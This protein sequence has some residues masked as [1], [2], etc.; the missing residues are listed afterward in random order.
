MAGAVAEPLIQRGPLLKIKE[1][2]QKKRTIS[3]EFFPPREAEGITN[4][5]R[6]IDR[7]SAFG[8]DFVSVTYGAGGSTRAF[9]EEITLHIK[10]ET[11]LEVMAHLTCVGQSQQEIHGVLERLDRAGVDNVIALRGDPPRG[12][13]DFVP[14]AG[15]FRHST[16]LIQHIK[17]NFQFGIAAACY[18]E[19]HTESPDLETDIRYARLKVDLGADFLITQLFYDNSDFF[20]FM[21]RAQQAGI[22]VPIIPGVLP[23]LSASQIRRFTALCGARIPPELD[24]QLD[25]YAGDDQAVRELGIEHASR[26]IRELWDGGVPGVH[27]YVLNR[28]YSVSRILT[29]LGLAD[30]TAGC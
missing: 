11:D 19:G 29:N 14:A 30:G 7:V 15:G 5:L 17:N 26:Q 3:C 24:R 18:P 23:I 16:D 13:T 12:Q 10:G 28:T 9:T 8:P 20:Q 6:A 1:I 22:D 2:L 21:D 25:K 27:F 4:V